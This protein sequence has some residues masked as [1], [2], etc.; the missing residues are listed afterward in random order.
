MKA[1]RDSLIALGVAPE[2]VHTEIFG[3]GAL[4]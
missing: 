3:S 1:Q 2:R 4:E